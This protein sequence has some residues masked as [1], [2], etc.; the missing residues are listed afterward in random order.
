[1]FD[2]FANF[3]RPESKAPTTG[4]ANAIGKRAELYMRAALRS[5]HIHVPRREARYIIEAPRETAEELIALA[6]QRTQP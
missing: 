5:P 3:E 1:M 4:A 6:L 2:E